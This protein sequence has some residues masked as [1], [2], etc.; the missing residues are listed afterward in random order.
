MFGQNSYV[1]QI[2]FTHYLDPLEMAALWQS[3]TIK[4]RANGR[5]ISVQQSKPNTIVI[6]VATKT[7]FRLNTW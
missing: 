7:Y 3:L 5:R 4:L 6:Q 1:S 2:L